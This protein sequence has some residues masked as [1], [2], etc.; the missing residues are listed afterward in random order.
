[1]SNLLKKRDLLKKSNLKKLRAIEL[2]GTQPNMTY[3]QVCKE[4]DIS[5]NTLKVWRED[6]AFVEAVYEKY[7]VTFN[8]KL[9]D[10]LEAMI[11]EAKEGNVQAARLVMD[12]AGKIVKRVNVKIQAPFQQFLDAS[13]GEVVDI[14]F[15]DMDEEIK[16]VGYTPNEIINSIPVSENLPERN[17]SNDK[18]QNRIIKEKKRIAKIKKNPK[19]IKKKKDQYNSWYHIRTRAKKV[20]LAPLPPGKPT[21]TQRA[22]W[23]KELERLESQKNSK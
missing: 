2:L 9:P 12:V 18:P 13:E 3:T 19:A 10:V 20:G 15:D 6:V 17:K 16:G 8:S 22:E 21:K 1:M 7:M 4:L 14:D 11:R 5:S 23:I